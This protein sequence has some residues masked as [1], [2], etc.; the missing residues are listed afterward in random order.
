MF[1]LDPL[2]RWVGL[3][4]SSSS[5]TAQGVVRLQRCWKKRHL[6]RNSKHA[7]THWDGAHSI[8]LVDSLP[9]CPLAMT[10]SVFARHQIPPEC[11]WE[12]QRNTYFSKPRATTP[13]A[14]SK[15][16]TAP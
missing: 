9:Y 12:L 7:R 11:R 15:V 3:Q 5:G 16:R 4:K 13:A 8:D 2:V 10:L 1:E 6:A 14:N